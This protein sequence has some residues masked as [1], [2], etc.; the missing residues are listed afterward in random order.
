MKLIQFQCQK[1]DH[2]WYPRREAIP[3]V[4]PVCKRFDWKKDSLKS[5]KAKGD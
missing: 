2:K 5:R 3:K 4:C 1:C